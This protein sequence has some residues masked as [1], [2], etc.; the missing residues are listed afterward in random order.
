MLW[1]LSTI[2]KDFLK[3]RLFSVLSWEKY[4]SWQDTRFTNVD[5]IKSGQMI[6]FFM[7]NKVK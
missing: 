2:E 4:S 1:A 5:M 7:A 6:V 3:I